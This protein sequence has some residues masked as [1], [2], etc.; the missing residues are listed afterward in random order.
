MCVS[1]SELDLAFNRITGE[2]KHAKIL[3]NSSTTRLKV[4]RLSGQLPTDGIAMATDLNIL[5]GNIFTCGDDLPQ[6]DKFHEDYACGSENL[7]ASLSLLAICTSCVL[8]LLG[9]I[10]WLCFRQGLTVHQSGHF[11]KGYDFQEKGIF[12][13]FVS[14]ARNQYCYFSVIRKLQVSPPTTL[15]NAQHVIRF[16]LDLIVITKLWVLL[17]LLSIVLSVPIYVLKVVDSDATTHDHEYGWQWSWVYT[18]GR[19]PALLLLCAWLCLICCFIFVIIYILWIFNTNVVAQKHKSEQ[20][21]AEPLSRRKGGVGD[22]AS[23][24]YTELWN[25][26]TVILLLL[27]NILVVGVNLLYIYSTS[28]HTIANELQLVIQLMLALFKQVNSTFVL[29]YLCRA[30]KDPEQAILVRLMISILQSLL[31]PCLSQLFRTQAVCG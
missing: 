12:K 31:V 27:N 8:I 5:L 19:L 7:N 2:Y 18:T 10:A 17:C 29:P 14:L 24:P 22:V 9:V 3:S 25:V 30:I 4:N 6:N 20:A 26:K 21:N 28:Q 16:Y 23:N 13:R 11:C 15:R 1:V